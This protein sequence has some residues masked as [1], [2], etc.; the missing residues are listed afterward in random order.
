MTATLVKWAAKAALGLTVVFLVLS[1]AFLYLAFRLT[2]WPIRKMR[3]AQAART[4][5]LVQVAQSLFVLAA[6][7][8]LSK[9]SLSTSQSDCGSA[10]SCTETDETQTENS[11]PITPIS[12]LK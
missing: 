11:P 9:R 5:A 8:K 12:S 3:P 10:G 2:T 1:L 4:A 7:V 6:A